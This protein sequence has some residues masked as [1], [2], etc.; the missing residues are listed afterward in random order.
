MSYEWRADLHSLS[1]QPPDHQ[2][3][4]IVHRRAFQTLLG[5]LPTGADCAG[6]FELHRPAFEQAAAAKISRARL[7]PDANFHLN[8]RDIRRAT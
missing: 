5:F 8:S 2:G 6:F 1:F 7:A 4:C 3:R